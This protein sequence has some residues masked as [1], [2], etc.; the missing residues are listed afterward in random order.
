MTT[1]V[2][3]TNTPGFGKVVNSNTPDINTP[4][5]VE[6][7]T[8]APPVSA[9]PG[10]APDDATPG[11][12]HHANSNPQM[13]K[14]DEYKKMTAK[15]PRT[16]GTVG[17]AGTPLVGANS[18]DAQTGQTTNSDAVGGVGNTLSV[19]NSGGLIGTTEPNR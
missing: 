3:E 13:V 9:Y 12:V 15:S 18:A 1:T 10:D 5:L 4:E 14:P 7:A 19:K 8:N 16:L 2:V 17:N 11:S 6:V